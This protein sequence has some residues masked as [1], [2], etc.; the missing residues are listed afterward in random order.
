MLE[1]WGHSRHRF[2]LRPGV[3]GIGRR[4]DGVD[5][6]IQK[7]LR[8]RDDLRPAVRGTT[9][10]FVWVLALGEVNDRDLRVEL[11]FEAD[12]AVGIRDGNIV[13]IECAT[14]RLDAAHRGKLA[15]GI[16]VE[17][18]HDVLREALHLPDLPLGQGGAHGGDHVPV[19]ELM[20]RNGVHVALDDHDL[21]P[22][23]DLLLGQ[24][25][26]VDEGAL[27]EDRGLGGVE[28]LGLTFAHDP[29][30]EADH[31][32]FAV[33]DREHEAP[34]EAVVVAAVLASLEQTRLSG[35]RRV[36]VA[37]GQEPEEGVPAINGVTKL[38]AVDH[39]TG[40][41]TLFRHLAAGRAGRA[42]GEDVGKEGGRQLIDLDQALTM[43]VD[44]RGDS[45]HGRELDPSAPGKLL[46][47]FLELHVLLAHVEREG[48]APFAAA[49]TV[50]VLGIREDDE[51]GRLLLMEWAEAL[52]A[53]AGP[54]QRRVG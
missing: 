2:G 3:G 51:G 38:E 43:G 23:A 15:G 39:L 17:G 5:E 44:L 4:G 18:K 48:V 1:D 32:S 41:A 54:R 53:A 26:A 21:I 28:V 45:R 29:S 20:G 27:V 40:E 30:A 14:H 34:A 37:G 42:V 12:D 33:P 8:L 9:D 16:G 11:A 31:P 22:L 13:L 46:Q 52:V 47:S 7:G 49:E 36:H 24:I 35:E 50:E 6:E 19:P 25:Q 10:Q